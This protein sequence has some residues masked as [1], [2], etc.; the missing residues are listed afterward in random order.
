MEMKKDR[1]K[2]QKDANLMENKIK[3]LSNEESKVAKK[4]N[5]QKQTQEEIEKIRRDIMS[6]KLAIE[7]VKAEKMK[8]AREKQYQIS[9]MKEKIRSAITDWRI[10]SKNKKNLEFAKFKDRSRLNAKLI[11][12]NKYEI[13]EKKKQQANEIRVKKL[14]TEEK[15]R[16]NET[17]KKMKMMLELEAKILDEERMKQMNVDKINE[18]ECKEVEILKRLQFEETVTNESKSNY[19]LNLATKEMSKTNSA[20]KKL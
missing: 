14:S 11:E 1:L 2:S 18:L 10:N 13:E 3:L 9:T 16:R 7:R 19:I 5:L 4:S 12:I 6:E 8:E 15:K 20:K 17:E